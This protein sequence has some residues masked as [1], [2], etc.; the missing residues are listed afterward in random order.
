M[1]S[2][3]SET[4]WDKQKRNNSP[5]EN[6]FQSTTGRKSDWRGQQEYKK[7]AQR[8][9]DAPSKTDSKQ[10]G[11]EREKAASSWQLSQHSWEQNNNKNTQYKK[12]K[13]SRTDSS[14]KENAQPKYSQQVSKNHPRQTDTIARPQNDKRKREIVCQATPSR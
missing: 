4:T 9:T 14:R 6:K 3:L 11:Q 2:P 13:E 1:R 5:T 7:T 10:V 12:C 8:R